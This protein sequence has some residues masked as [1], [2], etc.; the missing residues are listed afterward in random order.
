METLSPSAAIESGIL[1]PAGLVNL[2]NT[3]YANSVIQ[4]LHKIPEL[5]DA[6]KSYPDS[7]AA[8]GTPGALV[9]ELKK[10]FDAM[11]SSMT[12]VKPFNL[13][14]VHFSFIFHP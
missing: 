10:T 13:I 4:V 3:C 12:A 6:V 5:E 1:P 2:M 9:T 7:G 11:D 8:H 14:G